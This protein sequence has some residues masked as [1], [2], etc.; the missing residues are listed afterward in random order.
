MYDSSWGRNKTPRVSLV[1]TD[2]I[3]NV[4]LCSIVRAVHCSFFFLAWPGPLALSPSYRLNLVVSPRPFAPLDDA[5][6]KIPER[7][8]LKFFLLPF[9]WFI[10]FLPLFLWRGGDAVHAGRFERNDDK[11]LAHHVW[12]GSL[13]FKKI[14]ITASLMEHDYPLQYYTCNLCTKLTR[15][16]RTSWVELI[17]LAGTQ[18][19][20]ELLY[21]EQALLRRWSNF[22]SFPFFFV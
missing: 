18:F 3:L 22:I 20:I 14:N 11:N 19:S 4:Q 10:F 2:W 13:R 8:C 9:V 1:S 5:A 17:Q 16:S 6:V 21:D 15:F 12:L 7:P